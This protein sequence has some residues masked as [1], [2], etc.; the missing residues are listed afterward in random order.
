MRGTKLFS[1]ATKSDTGAESNECERKH[2]IACDCHPALDRWLWRSRLEYESCEGVVTT[3]EEDTGYH[4]H[5][6]DDSQ[7]DCDLS[8][9]FRRV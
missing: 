9:Y 4:N 3:C 5:I 6:N 7:E 1:I 2:K 8:A